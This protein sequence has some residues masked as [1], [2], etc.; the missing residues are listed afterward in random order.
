[1]GLPSWALDA[2]YRSAVRPVLFRVGGGDAEAAH[3]LT[4]RRMAQLGEHPSAI[5]ALG[6]GMPQPANPV[7]VAG[8]TFPGR[9]GLAAGVDKD[10]VGVKVWKHLGFGHIELGTV[11]AQAQ[12][13]NPHPRLFRLRGSDAIINRMGFN[14]NG[15]RALADR[16]AA[17]GPIGIPIGVS[18]GKTKVTPVEDAIG[19]YLTSL[20][21]LDAHADYFAVNVSSPNTP[22]L[23]S[24]QDKEPLAEL[25]AELVTATAARSRT[26]IFVK[27]A[28][29]LTDGAL[30]DVLEV[31]QRADA[32]GVIATN[33]TLSRD[34]IAD[35]DLPL[36]DE[37]GGLSGAPL[38]RRARHV[39][40]RIAQR[41]PL[42]VI[43]VGGVMTADDG[44][45]LI[46]AGASLV[47][48]YSGFIYRG[49]ALVAELNR[50]LA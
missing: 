28:P 49:P 23:R 6:L 24:L 27:I 7:E 19:D 8:I 17:A 22:G 14:N 16:L 2:G 47:Q 12:P 46:D 32:S 36:A 41:S 43:G 42:P 15:A 20:A 31:A 21:L 26:P 4:L 29:D 44:R 1:M 9:V 45:A 33:T 30:D 40:R 11:T 50:A 37:A 38:T 10:G 13:G 39:V 3:H 48:V 18:I 34:G 35:A 25:L 5:R